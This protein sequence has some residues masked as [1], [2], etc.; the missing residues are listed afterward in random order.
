M[1]ECMTMNSKNTEPAF[2]SEDVDK[3]KSTTSIDFATIC[4]K[5]LAFN[6]EANDLRDFIIDRG[7]AVDSVEF[8][9]DAN[10][11]FKGTAFVQ[12]DNQN[13]AN[14]VLEKLGNVID[15][16]GR[17]VKVQIQRRGK[18][19]R[20]SSASV[21]LADIL[22]PGEAEGIKDLI[23]DFA[24]DENRKSL[25]LPDSYSSEMRKY[26]HALAEKHGFQHLTR[27]VNADEGKSTFVYLSKQRMS[28]IEDDNTTATR[29]SRN[30]RVSTGIRPNVQTISTPIKHPYPSLNLRN[31]IPIYLSGRTGVS[32][33]HSVPIFLGGKNTPIG[34]KSDG[35]K[36]SRG[37]SQSAYISPGKGANMMK[38]LENPGRIGK[39]PPDW[40]PP[41][42]NPISPQAMQFEA[43]QQ[44][45]MYYA[46]RSSMLS[47]R[48]SDSKQNGGVLNPSL[49]HQNE[50]KEEAKEE[51][52][53]PLE[54]FAE[55][56][57]KAAQRKARKSSLSRR[58]S[59]EAASF[60]PHDEGALSP[61]EALSLADV[62]LKE[63]EVHKDVLR[64]DDENRRK[65][66][67]T[68][69]I[70][71]G[72]LTSPSFRLSVA[73]A[74]DPEPNLPPTSQ[75]FQLQLIPEGKDASGAP[76]VVVI[77]TQGAR[78]KFTVGLNGHLSPK[79]V[80][81]GAKFWVDF[82]KTLTLGST[83]ELSL[84]LNQWL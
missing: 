15:L 38:S 17:R 24:S 61:T 5:N 76:S 59:G 40:V 69:D 14:A 55:D 43:Q 16:N 65:I 33:R 23:N 4:F 49:F 9:H 72:H 39:H 22:K 11:A 67:W 48:S 29:L 53:S 52:I 46:M 77:C 84:E 51:A 54:K 12:F 75:P 2:D 83:V 13:T 20:Y 37:Y 71:A 42:S 7:F 56:D 81:L 31:S 27:V 80:L 60:I 28:K 21:S 19:D 79:K 66:T 58:L 74:A 34:R 68:C 10:G 82:P 44:T 30:S 36:G 63:V 18:R 26:A 78:M 47:A 50:K 64:Y 70:A 8:H 6:I 45:R 57:K 25:E 32:A 62:L 1:V 3:R 41:G 35:S 73:D